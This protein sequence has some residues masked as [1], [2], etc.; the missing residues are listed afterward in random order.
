MIQPVSRVPS[1]W[2][3]I[4]A[5]ARMPTVPAMNTHLWPILSPSMPNTG[6]VNKATAAPQ[7]VASS[8]T[9][10]AMPRVPVA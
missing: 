6:M 1:R 2:K 5:Q 10:R 4:G 9:E 8:I 7:I 3:N